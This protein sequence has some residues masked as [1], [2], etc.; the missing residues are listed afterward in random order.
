[1]KIAFDNLTTNKQELIK[2]RLFELKEKEN[3]NSKDMTLAEIGELIRLEDYV[4]GLSNCLGV[5]D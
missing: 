1:M 5:A 2:Q 4:L 3:N